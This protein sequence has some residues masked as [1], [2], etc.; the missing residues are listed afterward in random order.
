[1]KNT[2]NPR[3]HAAVALSVIFIC[4]SC[5][6]WDAHYAN[7]PQP[8]DN[9]LIEQ[10]E[11]S[12]CDYLSS[13]TQYQRITELL[14]SQHVFDEMK[15][16][17]LFYT[18]FVVPD[19][20]MNSLADDSSLVAKSHVMTSSLSPSS[21]SDGQRLLLWSN[22]YVSVLKRSGTT[23]TLMIGESN[24]TRV[25]KT[26]DGYI[27]E[28]DKMIEIPHSLLEIIAALPD[29]YSLFRNKIASMAE[30][31]FNKSAS[32]VLGVDESGNSIYDSVFVVKYP[33]FEQSGIDLNSA[34]TRFTMLIPSNELYRG[35]MQTAR[36]TLKK[37]DD[38]MN[39]RS[40]NGFY[41]KFYTSRDTAI[42]ENWIVQSA[43]FK[44]ELAPE[45]FH[46]PE[47]IDLYSA[48]SKQWRTTVNKVDTDHPIKM[49]NGTAYYMT[50]LKIPQNVL[51][52]R[53]KDFTLYYQYLTAADKDTFFVTDNFIFNRV[54]T[55]VGAWTPGEGWPM[56][57][58]TAVWF[59]MDDVSL[60]E[61]SLTFKAFWF[62]KHADN[63]YDLVPYM[64][65]AGE[66]TFH[67]GLCDIT[68][69]HGP[70]DVLLNNKKIA[71]Y[72]TSDLPGFSKDRSSGD[73]PEGYD[74]RL[75]DKYDRDG[76]QVSDYPVTLQGPDEDDGMV[77]VVI[78]W[79]VYNCDGSHIDPSHWTL[80]PTK[81][82][83]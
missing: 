65:P 36:A 64:V 72:Q 34:S 15:E 30:K 9:E 70:V 44:E 53:I 69:F 74:K 10:T 43:F 13:H 3:F 56:V 57:E 60:R 81:N 61:G 4:F 55:E 17:A 52:Y 35:A 37:W 38:R 7:D 47:N 23:D 49:S 29:E 77:P 27:Y 28:L 66:Y 33:F 24:V 39:T 59:Y 20:K 26:K 67:M 1:M 62:N 54:K 40:R 18:L 75:N 68:S 19:D 32:L 45:A 83:Y 48:F 2:P 11:L 25:V 42:L 6:D 58:N 21:V 73:Y 12:A 79:H 76:R 41:A 46:D 82:C 5:G 51:I 80:R 16:K 71:T 31:T 22:N 14:L 63:T 50:S 8:V 78:K